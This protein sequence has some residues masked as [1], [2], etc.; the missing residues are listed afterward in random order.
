MRLI[1]HTDLDGVFCAVLV[2][3][4]EQ[5]DD[6]KFIDPG[7]IQARKLSITENDILADL[8]Y[9]SRVGMWFDHHE[10]SKPKP[11]SKFEGAFSLAPSA[12]RVVFDY[13]ENPYLD[14]FKEAL[15]EVDR[16]DSGGV[17]L[18]EVQ[19]PYGWFLLSNLFETNSPKALD[20]RFRLHVI[21][22][23][24]TM[25]PVDVNKIL[26]D[27]KV[28][29]RVD[30]VSGEFEIF[31]KILLESTKIIGKVAFSD[32]R[33]RPDLPRGNNYIVYSLFPQ[34]TTSVRLMPLKE[35]KDFVKLSVGH[36]TFLPEGQ[37]PK[38]NV[39]E[40][41]KKLGGGGHA[42]VGGASLK[43]EEAD[44]IVKEIIEEINAS[45]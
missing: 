36:T 1:T 8:P 19:N 21:R 34:C 22:L 6:I 40:A 33:Q 17:R 13:F 23:M 2:S 39:G 38:F 11:G 4:V 9:D 41:M 12:A 24:R 44:R 18:E 25:E 32:L 30:R 31:K 29:E 35:D 10:S 3:S 43:K 5:I 27:K 26:E 28:K 15:V 7:T 16:I 45:S 37:K 42:A 20:D 14:K